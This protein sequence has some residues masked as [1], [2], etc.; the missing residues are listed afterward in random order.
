LFG[1]PTNDHAG[2]SDYT[3]VLDIIGE[4]LSEKQ[5]LDTRDAGYMRARELILMHKSKVV[6]LAER[7]AHEGRVDAPE[8]INL[9]SVAD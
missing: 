1:F 6:R 8:F 5:S 2:F 4:D 9:I 7:L 3:K